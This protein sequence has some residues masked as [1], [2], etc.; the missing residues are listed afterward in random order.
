[1]AIKTH[2]GPNGPGPCEAGQQGE[3][4]KSRGCPFASAEDHFDSAAAADREYQRRLTLAHEENLNHSFKKTKL[5]EKE[6]SLKTQT[7]KQAKEI[8]KL[9]SQIKGDT[10]VDGVDPQKANKR[11]LAAIAYAESRGN[12]HLADAISKSTVLGTGVIE[13]D[14]KRI[15]ADQVVRNNAVVKHF[16]AQRDRFVED[17]GRHIRHNPEA[18]EGFD[19]KSLRGPDGSLYTITRAEGMDETA[20]NDLSAAKRHAMTKAVEKVDIDLAREKLSPEKFAAITNPTAVTEFIMA[21]SIEKNPN[22]VDRQFSGKTGDEVLDN[23]LKKFSEFHT[24][25]V[26]KHGYIR[27]SRAVLKEGKAVAKAATADNGRNTFIPGKSHGNAM[28]IT[29]RRMVNRDAVY[30]SGVLTPAEIKAITKTELEPDEAKARTMLNDKDFNRIF[31]APKVSM[32][33]TEAKVKKEN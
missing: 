28:V 3:D 2:I 18:F 4:V 27:E 9:R 33:I 8:I 7:L 10:A 32:R 26:A 30:N 11:L 14:G 25:H 5:S 13:A 1:M 23:S 16:D 15:H 17:L 21:G 12:E 6:A 31:K 29:G 20:F 24:E 19:K 22:K